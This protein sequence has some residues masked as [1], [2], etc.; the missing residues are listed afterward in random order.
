MRWL[1]LP[2]QGGVKSKATM[3]KVYILQSL[4]NNRYYVGCTKDLPK[5]LLQH[6][7]G[8]NAST[9]KYRPWKIIYY[10]NFKNQEE[11]Y[12]CE[13]L[14]KSYKGGN[15][16]KKIISGEVAEWSKAAHC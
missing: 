5:R 16:F 13:K 12:K 4:K 11:A 2:R 14:V 3:H 7:N 8:E 1:S 10:R 15:A 9:S 6:N